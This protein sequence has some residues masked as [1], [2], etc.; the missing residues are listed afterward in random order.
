MCTPQSRG[1]VICDIINTLFLTL[2]LSNLLW[3]FLLAPANILPWPLVSFFQTSLNNSEFETTHNTFRD[4]RVP[5]FR[6][7]FSKQLYTSNNQRLQSAGD[8]DRTSKRFLRKRCGLRKFHVI[9]GQ[10]TRDFK[11]Q[12]RQKV[13]TRVTTLAFAA[14]HLFLVE[15]QTKLATYTRRMRNDNLEIRIAG[16]SCRPQ[17]TDS[18]HYLTSFLLKHL[19]WFI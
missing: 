16:S 6:Q 15:V 4:C 13:Q 7:P 8:I 3:S 1:K 19:G 12:E 2:W 10:N 14:F 5:F 9:D 17:L 11:N 18:Q